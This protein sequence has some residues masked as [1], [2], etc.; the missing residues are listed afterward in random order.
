VQI[1]VVDPSVSTALSFLT[2]ASWRA[3]TRTPTPKA[4]VMVGRGP[5]G[6]LPTSKPMANTAAAEKDSPAASVPSGKKGNPDTNR[7]D[8]DHP[9]HPPD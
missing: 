6:T 1:T 5:S 2:S 3:R 4:S 8:G 7:H 9:R